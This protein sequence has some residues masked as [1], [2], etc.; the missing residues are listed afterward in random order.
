[1]REGRFDQ[2]MEPAVPSASTSEVIMKDLSVRS[3]LVFW[4]VRV[5]RESKEGVSLSH[6][7]PEEGEASFETLSTGE[8][9]W[10]KNGMS[11][12]LVGESG[13][14]G[15]LDERLGGEGRFSNPHQQ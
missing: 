15:C 10:E 12:K 7:E 4:Y 11:G 1:M 8:E 3:C 6:L 13:V 5:I 14:D 2:R 9:I